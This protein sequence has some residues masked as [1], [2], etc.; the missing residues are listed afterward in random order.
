MFQNVLVAAYALIFLT[1]LVSF[2]HA[3]LSVKLTGAQSEVGQRDTAN[4]LSRC[5]GEFKTGK[6]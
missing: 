5:T 3:Y 2:L 6:K 4:A 1:F